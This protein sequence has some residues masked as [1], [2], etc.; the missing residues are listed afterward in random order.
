MLQ[1]FCGEILFVGLT[2]SITKTIDLRK[3]ADIEFPAVKFLIKGRL[4]ASSVH[5]NFVKEG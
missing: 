1:V 5:K 2:V 3:L 4:F